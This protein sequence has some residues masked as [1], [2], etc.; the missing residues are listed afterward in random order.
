MKLLEA[1]EAW[2]GFILVLICLSIFLA[3]IFIWTGAKLAGNEN[4]DFKKILKT[5]ILSSL[6]VYIT[7]VILSSL[8]FSNA[9]IGFILGLLLLPIIIKIILN[10][11]LKQTFVFWV[12]SVVSHFLAL[13]IGATLF[14]GGMKDL[15]KIL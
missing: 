3:I 12:F 13:W 2:T 1:I 4:L 8:S 6:F 14:I 9:V 10:S 15:I 11:T 5:I 7:T